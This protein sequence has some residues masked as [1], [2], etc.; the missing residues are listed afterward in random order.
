MPL[1]V[2]HHFAG[3][4]GLAACSLTSCNLHPCYPN[5]PGPQ[6]FG[7]AFSTDTLGTGK[8]FRKAEAFSAYLVRYRGADFSQPLDTLRASDR[9]KLPMVFYYVDRTLFCN[10]PA[11]GSPSDPHSYR[12][13]VPAS[14]KRYDIS[15]I[16]LEYGGVDNCT[17]TIGRF[18]A[19]INGQRVDTRRG[20]VATK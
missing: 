2:K 4:L 19:L 6:P 20:Y 8:G 11:V 16:V 5:D 13:E 17:R 10:F 7:V 18:D 14:Q 12:L 3:W 1:R 9:P 15:D